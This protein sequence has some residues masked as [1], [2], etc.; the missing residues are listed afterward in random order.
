MSLCPCDITHTIRIS[1]C[2]FSLLL[3][4]L[5]LFLSRVFF[6]WR[7]S[8]LWRDGIFCPSSL[9][10]ID[11]SKD[12]ISLC[13]SSNMLHTK[14]HWSGCS[15]AF[16]FGW[17]SDRIDRPLFSLYT[18]ISQIY[19]N[20]SVLLDGFFF[21]SRCCCVASFLPIRLCINLIC[22][23]HIL[24]QTLS[25]LLHSLQPQHVLRFARAY[26]THQNRPLLHSTYFQWL[27]SFIFCILGACDYFF[28]FI[29]HYQAANKT[30]LQSNGL[31]FIK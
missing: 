10:S 15:L 9:R 24:Q 21:L 31:Y 20:S 25:L 6:F 7:A 12:S 28:F 27:H 26:S 30:H 23:L 16:G 13:S 18:V 22:L 3:L 17:F 19:V 1:Q 2:F 29:K 11:N 14:T 4:V 5:V 8:S